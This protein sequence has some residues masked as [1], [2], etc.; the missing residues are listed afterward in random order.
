[1]KSVC[2]FLGSNPG[3]NPSYVAMARALGHELAS[4]GLTL[5]YGGSSVGLMG[6][7]A[8]TVLAAGGR[9]VGVIPQALKDKEIAHGHLDELHVVESMHERKARMA[10]L[11]EA[12]IALP[13]GLGT[14]EEFFEVLTWNQL[15]FLS[16]PCGLLNVNDYWNGLYR[17]LDTATEQGFIPEH[18]RR[19]ILSADT[20]A[21]L[22]SQ[23][24]GYVPVS[25]KKW[26]DRSTQ[27]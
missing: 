15:G 27:L 7:L 2:V 10:D 3:R 5:V 6:V 21:G 25:T 4:R 13:G 23:F 9:A 19:M 1:M 11:A 26:M 20:P 22:L 14:L 24:A 12:F 16:K 8:D 17:F 18:H